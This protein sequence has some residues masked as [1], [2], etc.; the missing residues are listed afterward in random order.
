MKY[1]FFDTETT[2]VPRNYKAPITDTDNW[3]R[4]VQLGAI[5][6]DEEGTVLDAINLVVYPDGFSIP[7]EASDVHGITTE[8]A[9]EIG[10]PLLD[11]LAQYCELLQQADV[12][13]GHNISFDIHIVGAELYRQGMNTLQLMGKKSVCTMQSSIQYC[14]IPGKYG[15]KWPKLIELH[16]VLFGCGFDGAHDAMADIRATKDCF[17]ELQKR[18]VV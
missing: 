16:E 18:G 2:G 9:R 3:P 5:L 11:V 6:A 14:N 15:P 1:L 10:Q 8:R 7:K 17:Y 4:L 13:V 12:V